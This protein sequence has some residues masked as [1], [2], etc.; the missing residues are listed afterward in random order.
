MEEINLAKK[1]LKEAIKDNPY[2]KIPEAELSKIYFL[3]EK[4]DSAIYYGK[5]AFEG[6]KKILFILLTM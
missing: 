2:I 3:E 1:Y 5:L 6:I 4:K